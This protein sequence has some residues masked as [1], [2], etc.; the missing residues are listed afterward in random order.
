MHAKR[1]C[2]R[3]MLKV[4]DMLVS[5]KVFTYVSPT[6]KSMNSST[7]GVETKAGPSQVFPQTTCLVKRLSFCRTCKNKRNKKHYVFTAKSCK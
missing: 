1:T 3:N 7:G 6:S 4:F 5:V 2:G